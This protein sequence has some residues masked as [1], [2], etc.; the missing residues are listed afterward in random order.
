MTPGAANAAGGMDGEES[1]GCLRNAP[2]TASSDQG[3]ANSATR[4]PDA[5]ANT[6]P[7]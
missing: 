7:F 5:S 3:R 1:E 6:V 2:W 4:L